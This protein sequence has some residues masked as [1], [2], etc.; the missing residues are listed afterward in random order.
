MSR[1]ARALKSLDNYSLGIALV[2][3][4]EV[5]PTEHTAEISIFLEELLSRQKPNGAWGYAYETRG[6]TS[7][8]QYAALGIW[9]AKAAGCSV[10]DE[11]AVNLM[12]YVMRVQD[13]EWGLGLPRERSRHIYARVRRRR[14]VRRWRPPV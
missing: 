7:Q 10:S 5:H 11:V 6:D 8:L 3:L 13:P 12:N 4:T 9:S 14:C 1:D 2:F